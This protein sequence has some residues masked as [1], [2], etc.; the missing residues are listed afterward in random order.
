MGTRAFSH[1][2]IFMPDGQ[3]E[4]EKDSQTMSQ[5]NI[6]GKV[7]TLQQQLAKNICLGQPPASGSGKRMQE[8]DAGA[9]EM[10][11]AR[12]APMQNLTEQG[13]GLLENNDMAVG[14]PSSFSSR[15]L[16]FPETEQKAEE[17]A[18][19]VKSFRSR[20]LLAASG[21]IESI[22]L[23]AVPRSIAR[24][25]NSAAKHKLSVKPKHQ[26]LSKQHRGMSKDQQSIEDMEFENEIIYN[27][28][29]SPDKATRHSPEKSIEN[30]NLQDQL[31][32]NRHEEQTLNKVQA[33]IQKQDED[34]SKKRLEEQKH[35]ELL[36]KKYEEESQRLDE[37]KKQKLEAQKREEEEERD[38]QDILRCLEVEKLQQKREEQKQIEIKE[39]QRY[40]EET[41]RR[42]EQ[43]FQELEED[44][45]QEV[46]KLRE[47]EEQRCL[48]HVEEQRQEV[49]RRKRDEEKRLEKEKQQDLEM[50]KPSEKQNE[51]KIE[52]VRKQV[53]KEEVRVGTAELSLMDKEPPEKQ[54][55]KAEINQ[56]DKDLSQRQLKQI[57]AQ[58]QERIGEELRWQELDQRQT[59]PRPYTFQ[60]SSGE[61]QIIFQK[62]NLSPVTPLKESATSPDTQGP[63]E[64]KPNL[65]SHALSSS[66]CVPHTAILV[67]GA[68]LCGTAVDLNQ[69]KDS[70]CKSLLGLTE[71]RKHQDNQPTENA[72]DKCDA[73]H[74]SSKTKYTSESLDNQSMLA[75]WASIRSKILKKSE[76]VNML[77]KEQ[78]SRY[79]D[80]WTAKWKGDSHSNLRKTM[81]ASAKFSITPAWQK[82]AETVK[83]REVDRETTL[84][85]SNGE[86][87]A[88]KPLS[89][90]NTTE[91][92][93]PESTGNVQE[94]I[95]NKTK[96]QITVED[97]TE[98]CKFAKDLP[99]FLVP[100]PPQSPRRGQSQAE[101][102]VSLETQMSTRKTDKLLQNAEEKTSP[103][104]IK[105]RRTN[106]SLKFHSDLQ[107]EQK[108]KKRYSAG[109]SF[110]GVPVPFIAADETESR[111]VSKKE[112][113]ASPSKVKKDTVMNDLVDTSNNP[114]SNLHSTVTP[115]TPVSSTYVTSPNK[116]RMVPKSPVTQ[117]PSLAPKPPSPTPPPSPLSKLNRTHLTDLSGQSLGKSEP[118]TITSSENIKVNAAVLPSPYHDRNEE[119]ETKERKCSFP[120]IP[121]PWRDKSDKRQ[122]LNRKERPVLQSRHSLDGSR[123]MDKVESAQPL[124][125][126]LALQKQKGFREQQAS[127][128]ER[129]QVREAKQADKLAKENDGVSNQTTEYRSRTGSLQKSATQEEEKKCE[130][131]VSLLQRREQLQKSNTLPTSVTVEI[132]DSVPVPPLAR[133]LPKRFSTPDATPV[134]SEP[135]WLALAKRKAKAWSDCP[136]IIK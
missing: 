20:R 103:F 115:L 133:E 95:T 130:T 77:D 18:T 91:N 104:G 107:N 127:R 21:T 23:D 89:S 125:I 97:N 13:T 85:Q 53:Q 116:D 114:S 67:T 126:T 118:D 54:K 106:Y 12:S 105:L 16:P 61:K 117:R 62:V 32:W 57:E 59:M 90:D 79:S 94:T 71:E 131:V 49:E 55:T 102:L 69:I 108:K 78:M 15:N 6:V 36:K 65:S 4:D 113:S 122:E 37:E 111:S 124:W 72:K 1:D 30:M 84:K 82:F 135:A 123:L 76:N 44:R 134:S 26:R 92:K 63:K 56:G 101:T 17:K 50:Q 48:K 132:A 11:S 83:S 52:A 45:R 3:A 34:D 75:E 24:L 87:V 128:E 19:P 109:D 35:Q 129:R 112:L 51:Q 74:I 70:T 73:K 98:G 38:R 100:N 2:S 33:S 120:S 121:I 86:N 58:Q 40:E 27:M 31:E 96:K 5:D 60:V 22:N 14:S 41:K 99:S 68:Q 64:H 29:Q 28:Q 43:I 39:Q 10:D 47:L 46:Q 42:V 8:L 88:A 80:D 136:Q 110:D 7:K 119:D 66:M 93:S 81:S 9:E 25:D